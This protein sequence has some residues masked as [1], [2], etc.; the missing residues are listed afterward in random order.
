M[1]VQAGMEQT[2]EILSTTKWLGEDQ[3]D[4]FLI[5]ALQFSLGFGLHGCSLFFLVFYW[6]TGNLYPASGIFSCI[7]V[8]EKFVLNDWKLIY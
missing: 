4:E 6:K 1:K 7:E 5:P 3:E 2:A 8:C